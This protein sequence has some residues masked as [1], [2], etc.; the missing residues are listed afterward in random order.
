[1]IWYGM[2]WYGMVWYGMVW[3]GMVRYGMEKN[4]NF[5]IQ[6]MQTS[7]FN[8]QISDFKFQIAASVFKFQSMFKFQAFKYKISKFKL[9]QRLIFLYSYTYYYTPPSFHQERM[10]PSQAKVNITQWNGKT[11]KS[12]EEEEGCLGVDPVQPLRH[13]GW[14][15]MVEMQWLR[16]NETKWLRQ[17]QLKQK[18][19][20]KSRSATMN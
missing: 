17:K 6:N 19:L 13:R 7:H 1:M 15:T 12:G 11:Q 8:I 5:R 18:W 9:Q 16:H 20:R 10:R 3:Y 2:V 14:D 4:Q